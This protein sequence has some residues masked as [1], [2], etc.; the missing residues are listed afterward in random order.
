LSLQV[1]RTCTHRRLGRGQQPAVP[2]PKKLCSGRIASE[3]R[4]LS[5]GIGLGPIIFRSNDL[6]GGGWVG[7]HRPQTTSATARRCRPQPKTISATRKIHIGHKP[8]RP[9]NMVSLLRLII[10]LLHDYIMVSYSVSC[11]L[12]LSALSVVI[13]RD[14]FVSLFHFCVCQ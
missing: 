11:S 12:C 13:R 1:L 4:M 5:L 10:S 14:L 8:Y 2:K 6:L 7:P 9:Q 3:G